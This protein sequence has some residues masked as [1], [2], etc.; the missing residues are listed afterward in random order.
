MSLEFL[1]IIRGVLLVQEGNHPMHVR[2]LLYAMLPEAITDVIDNRDEP[3][4]MLGG[5]C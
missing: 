5:N 3:E 2:K 4:E 1:L